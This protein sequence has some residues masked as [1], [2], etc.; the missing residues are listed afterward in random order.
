MGWTVVTDHHPLDPTFPEWG[1]SRYWHLRLSGTV[2]VQRALEHLAVLLPVLDDARSHWL[3]DEDV[4]LLLRRGADWLAGHPERELITSRYLRRDRRLA[5]AALAR[6]VEADGLAEDPEAEVAHQDQEEQ[7]IEAVAP[8]GTPK[9]NDQRI[10]AV[11]AAITASG[12]RTVVDLGCGE[13]QLVRALL[14]RTDIDRVTGV[15]VSHGAL[16]VAARRL[17]LDDMAP[18]QRQR[19]ELIQGA[20]TYR[21]RRLEGHDL[22]VLMEVIEHVDP[23]RLDALERAV[24]VHVRPATVLVTTPNVEHNVRYDTLPAG[25]LRH[26]DHRF[27]WTRAQFAQW[28]AGVADRHGYRVELSGIGSDDA[29]VGAPTQMAVFAR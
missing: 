10:E 2:V 22:A 17:H 4:E 28:C 9:L 5:S 19:L 27:E 23:E 1:D 15:D 29:E 7:T 25:Q 16:R 21:D 13:G 3:A 8:A 14:R 11:L 24:F 26:R 12:A 20:L 18:R 6:L